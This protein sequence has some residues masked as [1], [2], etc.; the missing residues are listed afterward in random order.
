VAE[1]HEHFDF[2]LGHRS[3]S[4]RRIGYAVGRGGTVLSKAKCAIEI[5]RI[6]FASNG[7]VSLN[8]GLLKFVFLF[9][10]FG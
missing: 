5:K 9:V 2:C 10:H 7:T 1:R 3:R 6:R 4:T 8:L